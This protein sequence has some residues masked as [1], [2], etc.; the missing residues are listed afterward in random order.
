MRKIFIAVLLMFTLTGCGSKDATL[1]TEQTLKLGL[2]PAVDTAPIFHALEAGYF[3]E[4]NLNVEL[5]V[6]TSAQDRQTALQTNSIDGA[7]TDLIAV[8]T[9]VN[10]GFEFK[11]TTLTNGT[12]MMLGN[13]GVMDKEELNVGL[14]EISVSNYL[15]DYW[16]GDDYVINKTYIN[17][18]PARLEAVATN[19]LDMGF[20]P[21]PVASVGN[22]NGLEKL[23]FSYPYDQFPDVLVFTN[24]SI[25]EKED[26]IIAFHAAYNKAVLDLVE[27][28]SI[29][30][31]TLM[32]NVPN[33]PEFVKDMMVLPEYKAVSLPTEDYLNDIIEWTNTILEEPLSVD[34]SD[35]IDD[36]FYKAVN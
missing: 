4:L 22:K 3:E 35:F 31:E 33:L 17:A 12:F 2:M 30:R 11:A 8:A 10:A 20:F 1:E 19:Q 13:P 34:P 14:M 32:R 26:A 27:D 7:L 23:E 24:K 6:Y 15:V 25:E 16:L 21:E 29:A 36:T 18:I 9:N 5:E 28:D